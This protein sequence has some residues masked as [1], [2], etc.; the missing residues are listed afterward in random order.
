M[1][2]KDSTKLFIW[3][4]EDPRNRKG[5]FVYRAPGP[6]TNPNSVSLLGTDGRDGDTL[7]SQIEQKLGLVTAANDWRALASVPNTANN[8]VNHVFELI[9]P[10]R[11]LTL[12]HDAYGGFMVFAPATL[13][14]FAGEGAPIRLSPALAS[15]MAALPEV[16]GHG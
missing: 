13:W 1:K 6:W 4:S 16:F 11:G 5:F 7:V 9:R 12:N 2:E 10:L 8:E 14:Q 15:I 3:T